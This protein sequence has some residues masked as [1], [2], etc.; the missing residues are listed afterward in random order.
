MNPPVQQA[1]QY[2]D[3]EEELEEFNPYL[4]IKQL[5]KYESVRIDGKV[6]SRVWSDLRG[7][8]STMKYSRP[9]FL[10][11]YGDS[12]LQ[13]VRGAMQRLQTSQKRQQ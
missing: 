3:E 12:Q 4:F 5:P 1:V 9:F 7:M 10:S 2:E 13:I 6:R 8:C 11:D